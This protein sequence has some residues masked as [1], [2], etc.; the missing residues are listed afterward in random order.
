[1]TVEVID[2]ELAFIEF[3]K[4]RIGIEAYADV[5]NPR[6][7]EFVTVERTGGARDSVVIDNPVLA[8]Q[9]WA[10]TRYE[11]SA[12][13]REVD[14]VLPDFAYEP[15]ICKVDRASLYNFPDEEGGDGRYQIV[16]E[17]KTTN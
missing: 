7:S 13:A 9:C 6:P 8:I 4:A 17:I 2:V 16:A 12:L 3:V 15:G 1:M 14:G 5:P 10:K 11:A